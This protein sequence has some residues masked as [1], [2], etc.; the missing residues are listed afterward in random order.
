M[1]SEDIRKLLS[2]YY[3]GESTE[4]EELILK[5]FFREGDVPED[6]LSE[7]GIFNYYDRL[8]IIPAPGPDFENKIIS[9]VEKENKFQ[10]PVQGRRL[11]FSI[12]GIAAGLLILAGSYFFFFHRTETKDTFSDPEIAYAETMKILYNVSA[13]LNSGAQLF[14]SSG[15]I[16]DVT[17]K[18]LNKINKSTVIFE[19]KIKTLNHLDKA[20]GIINPVDFR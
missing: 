4:K 7:K 6:L 19:E 18:S 1:N 16:Q 13:R 11:L 8:V 3:E 20:M 15:L 9:A 5:Q 10:I 17:G 12:A 2:R 14:E